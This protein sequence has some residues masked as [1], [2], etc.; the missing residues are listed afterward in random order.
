MAPVEI[1][2]LSVT[3]TKEKIRNFLCLPSASS[4]RFPR[5]CWGLFFNINHVCVCLC[6]KIPSHCT[7]DFYHLTGNE[8]FHPSAGSHIIFSEC[9][10]RHPVLAPSFNWNSHWTRVLLVFTAVRCAALHAPRLKLSHCPDHSGTSV[11]QRQV[12]GRA[13]AFGSRSGT[14]RCAREQ[15]PRARECTSKE[16]G[17]HSA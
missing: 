11:S 6:A 14:H 5:F 1:S 15:S 13:G 3:D 16:Q 2:E 10:E 9:I 17:G 7:P 8:H 4:Q 12:P